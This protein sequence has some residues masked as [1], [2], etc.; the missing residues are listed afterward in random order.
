MKA[1]TQG[2]SAIQILDCETPTNC[3][4]NREPKGA[5]ASNARGHDIERITRQ[6]GATV[7]TGILPWL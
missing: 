6:H 4:D 5:K 1:S 7:G 2:M 3:R